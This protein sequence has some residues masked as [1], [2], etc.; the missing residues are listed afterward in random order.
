MTCKRKQILKPPLWDSGYGEPA[1]TVLRRLAPDE[2]AAFFQDW[3]KDAFS[4]QDVTV[5]ARQRSVTTYHGVMP[6]G[7]TPS[8]VGARLY[9]RQG[10]LQ[11]HH[12]DAFLG[13]LE[14]CDLT[15][16][17]LITTGEVT[18][19]ARAIVL[20]NR[21]VLWSGEEWV[22]QLV[23]AGYVKPCVRSAWLA[24]VIRGSCLRHSKHAKRG[25][26]CR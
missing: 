22:E 6:H 5:T 15:A 3:L 21:I 8:P 4:L 24:E 18:P 14:R 13:Y 16:G 26:R 7:L 19:E 1:L 10:R 23:D 25:Q 11:A 12:V 17:I 9:Q 2:L 20:S